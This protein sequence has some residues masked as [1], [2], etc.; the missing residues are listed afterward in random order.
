MA[1]FPFSP[2]VTGFGIV[3]Y[4]TCFGGNVLPQLRYSDPG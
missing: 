1:F 2:R 3:D 4:Q